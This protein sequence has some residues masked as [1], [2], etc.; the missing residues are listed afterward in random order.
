MSAQLGVAYADKFSLITGSLSTPIITAHDL[1]CI[2]TH[3]LGFRSAHL[4]EQGEDF[5]PVKQR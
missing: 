2:G 3:G 5:I 4:T 1:V